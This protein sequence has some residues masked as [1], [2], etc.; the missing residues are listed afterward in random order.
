MSSSRSSSGSVASSC[1]SRWMS[2]SN[3]SRC[4]RIEMYSPAAIENAPA[5]SPATPASTMIV[6]STAAP[7][8]PMIRDRFDT[9][10][11]LT[12]KM[13]ARRAPL[14]PPATVPSPFSATGPRWGRIVSSRLLNS[15]RSMLRSAPVATS[16]ARSRRF[17]APAVVPEELL[18][19]LVVR[20]APDHRHRPGVGDVGQERPQRDQPFGLER[21]AEVHDGRPEGPPPHVRLGAREQH[22]VP[23]LHPGVVELAGRPFDDPGHPVHEADRGPADLEVEELLGV[24]AG[25]RGGLPGLLEVARGRARGLA[26][27]V[28]A[29]ERGHQDGP[30]HLGTLGEH[31]GVHCQEDYPGA[32]RG[33]RRAARLPAGG[34]VTAPGDLLERSRAALKSRT[35]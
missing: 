15:P 23:P 10:P 20:G 30:L 7:V 2:R 24:D 8:N 3:T 9:R 26:G 11:S 6:L 27:V 18:D 16:S 33:T 21:P 22:D 12:P 1:A 34:P 13:A 14:R 17:L 35:R 29:P 31:D 28:P 19:L 5:R 4:D 32:R 25:E